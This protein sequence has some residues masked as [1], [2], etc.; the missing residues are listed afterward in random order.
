MS[1][2]TVYTTKEIAE[3]TGVTP[4]RIHQ[5]RN[6]QIV[7]LKK[8]GKKYEIKPY[9]TKGIHW[10]WKDTDVIFFPEGLQAILKR[11]TKTKG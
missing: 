5:L 10:D 6:G 8:F 7:N 2:E 3:I 1:Q 4:P 9:L 11:R